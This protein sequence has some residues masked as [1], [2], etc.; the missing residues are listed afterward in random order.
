M[1]FGRKIPRGR[2]PVF[3]VADER[4]AEALIVLTC[5]RTYDGEYVARELVDAQTLEN[6]RRFSDRL[7]LAHEAMRAAGHCR[8]LTSV[9]DRQA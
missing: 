4:E 3:A 5:P 7:A 2:L 6:L 1:G 8:C 9:V